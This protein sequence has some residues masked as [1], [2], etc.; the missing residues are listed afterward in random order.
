M[1]HRTLVAAILALFA[2]AV[3][4][5]YR[6]KSCLKIDTGWNM[7]CVPAQFRPYSQYLL[8]YDQA[9]TYMVLLQN[10]TEM[11]ANGGF[12][13]SY[14]VVTL[15]KGHISAR[16]QDIYAPDG[17]LGAGHVEAPK[18]IEEAFRKG[19]FMLR[20]SDWDPDF[21]QAANTIRWFFDKGGEIKPDLLLTVSLSTI[22]KVLE[23]TGPLDIP[24]YQMTLNSENIFNLLQAKVESDFFPGSTQKKDILSGVGQ[25]LLMRVMALEVKQ[26]VEIAKLLY[27]EAKHENILANS[28]N[29][30]V[31]DKLVEWNL[32][33][34][35][36]YPKCLHDG[37]NLDTFMAI[38]ANLGANKAN[39][40][41]TRVTKHK[42]T[43][44]GSKLKHEVEISYTNTSSL[45][46]PRLPDFF[47]GN[48]IDY[49]RFYIPK[50]AEN[51][52]VV[53]SPTLPTTLAYYPEPY[54]TDKARLD[55]SDFYLFKVVGMFHTTQAGT[56]S[57]IQMSYELPQSG[58]YELHIA[59]QHG[60][61]SSP[62]E[63]KY[64]DQEVSTQL[65]DDFV[66]SSEI[67]N[68]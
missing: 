37:C 6:V 55:V 59:K 2:C 8:G 35:L 43:P 51:L 32:A 3:Y 34:K 54:T 30:S 24:D 26:K 66:F 23:I 57:R 36:S 27:S 63:I 67:N 47:G 14:A 5:G 11:R 64:L 9:T 50:Q 12:F 65:E 29:P 44:D 49:V 15:D 60:M 48:Y 38:E 18:P 16:F 39:C 1:I 68:K 56:T 40:C 53:G 52:E 13:G 4:L 22:K 33:G 45:E 41:T 10:D 31:Q 7:R 58:E 20:D 21:T 19:G 62:Q 61:V 42:I 28:L 25:V 46:N 17:Q